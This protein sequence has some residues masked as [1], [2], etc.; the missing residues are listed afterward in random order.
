MGGEFWVGWTVWL[1][2]P[3]RADRFSCLLL[4]L[5]LSLLL[6]ALTCANASFARRPLA[7]GLFYY[8]RRVCPVCIVYRVLCI[9]R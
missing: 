5:L 8:W 7:N 9:M 2:R 6:L 3:A 4:L 1:K